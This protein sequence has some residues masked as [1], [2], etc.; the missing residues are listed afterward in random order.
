[1][2]IKITEDEKFEITKNGDYINIGVLVICY[3]CERH[4]KGTCEGECVDGWRHDPEAG[5]TFPVKKLNKILLVLKAF[6]ILG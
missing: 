1:M 2:I 6:K 5:L 3:L 4:R